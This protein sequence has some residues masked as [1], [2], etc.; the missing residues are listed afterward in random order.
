MLE[1]VRP[2]LSNMKKFELILDPKLE[3]NYSLKSAQMLAAVANLCLVRQA[4]SRPK[5]SE[6]LEMVN[7]IM[8]TTDIGVPQLFP[9][10]SLAAEE[11]SI[12]SKRER[13]KRTFLDPLTRE[14][15]CLNCGTWRRKVVMFNML[16]RNE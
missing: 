9:I 14:N 3:G 5:M 8:E 12:G 11:D 6:I 13:F 7:R 10:V 15:S 1:W 2:H 4:K 16:G